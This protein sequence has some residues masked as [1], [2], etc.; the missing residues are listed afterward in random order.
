MHNSIGGPN[1]YQSSLSP[2]SCYLSHLPASL[3]FNHW[4]P[5]LWYFI[6]L[7]ISL[8]LPFMTYELTVLSLFPY[9]YLS[10]F[11]YAFL[12]L[13]LY[14]PQLSVILTFFL[15]LFPAPYGFWVIFASL[16]VTKQFTWCC[17]KLPILGRDVSCFGG[18]RQHPCATNG[19][20]TTSFD[21][22]LNLKAS[23]GWWSNS[24]C[25]HHSAKG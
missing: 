13:T 10:F 19:A 25:K 21:K 15:H 24:E 17:L 16:L 7:F 9:A 12:F 8:P 2:F 6:F 3:T 1:F 23:K 11:I 4:F 22:L 18:A 14:F 5:S 20:Y